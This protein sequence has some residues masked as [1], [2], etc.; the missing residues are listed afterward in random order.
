MSHIRE[1]PDAWRNFLALEDTPVDYA[2]LGGQF[3]RINGTPDGLEFTDDVLQKSGG[4]MAGDLILNADPT[5]VLGAVT[6]QYVDGVASGLDWKQSVRIA[7]TGAITLANEQTI[8]GVG[9]VAGDRVLVKNQG[10]GASHVDNGI[11]DVVAGGNWTR[12]EDADTDADV[13]AGMAMFVEE[14]TANKDSAF[15]LI[16]NDPITV[17]TTALEFSLF[18][19]PGAYT[20][21]TGLTESPARTFNA[22]FEDTDGN[23]LDVGT[24]DAGVSD[25]VARA[26]HVH[27]HGDQSG[28]TEHA[29]AT[30]SVAG[31]LSAADKEKLDDLLAGVGAGTV[32]GQTLV[33]DTDAWVLSDNLFNDVTNSFVGANT[34]SPHSTIH[35]NGSF[36]AKLLTVTAS[37]DL[38]VSTNQHVKTI[39][40]NN[41][42]SATIALPSAVGIAGREYNIKKVSATGGGRTV[43]IDAD[44]TEQ[45]D[46]SLTFS[47]TSQYEAVTVISD[48][49]NWWIV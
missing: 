23:I 31:F 8:D 47:L 4:T 49:A 20:A 7:T 27:A 26:D 30:T 43:V 13:T 1:V 41:A 24:Q 28:G 39:I 19:S 29:E 25:K 40:V 21:G 3:V 42:A 45:I 32:D 9:V 22:D 15:V 37:Y 18:S 17:D 34:A 36:A 33:W 44:D 14:G 48:G 12:S 10:G 5:N 46:G 38:T 11:Y 35:A 2:A 6:K 16:T